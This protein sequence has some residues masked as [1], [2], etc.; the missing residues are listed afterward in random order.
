MSTKEIQQTANGNSDR[1]V[2]EAIRRG[3]SRAFDALFRQH[4]GALCAYAVRM[5][6][7][8]P[9]EAE[10]V[11]QQVFIKLWEQRNDLEI[12]WTLKSYLYKMVHNRCLNRIRDR[13]NRERNLELRERTRDQVVQPSEGR[14]E[15][16]KHRLNTALNQLP[17]QCRQVFELSRFEELKY[18]EI[19][20]QLNISVKTVEA[21]MGKA[22]KYMRSH[23]SD[24]FALMLLYLF[25]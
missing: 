24:L 6:D 16:L 8:D 9:D 1:G 5:T 18:R 3:D 15:E 20:D 17:P 22:L 7:D 11:V 4:Y 14:E 23:L 12:R 10:D 25:M 21:Q 19:A 13:Q 2:V